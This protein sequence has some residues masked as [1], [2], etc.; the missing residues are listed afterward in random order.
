MRTILTLVQDIELLYTSQD[1]EQIHFLQDKL[2]TYQKSEHGDELGL[3]LLQ[4]PHGTVKYFGALTITVYLNTYGSKNYEQTFQQILLVIKELTDENFHSNSFII[5]KLLSCL[6]LIYIL[7]YEKFDPVLTFIKL[8]NPANASIGEFIVNLKDSKHLELLLYL[9]STIVEEVQKIP[10]SI[11]E[12]Q[13]TIHATIFNH[14]QTVLEYILQQYSQLPEEFI[15]L[16]LECLNSWVVYASTAEARSEVRYADDLRPFITLILK[17]LDDGFD[18]EKFEVYNKTFSVLAE[19]VDHIARALTP[20]KATLMDIFFGGEKFGMQMLNTIFSDQ[21]LMETYGSEVDN[22]INLIIGY[23]EL[24][25]IQLTRNILHPDTAKIV[26][27]AI[28]LTNAPGLP[29]VEENIS[30]Q[31]ISFWD[32]FAN[33]LIDDADVLKEAFPTLVA[34]NKQRS[35]D[36]LMEVAIVYFKKIQKSSNDVSQEF[37]RYRVLVADL[38]IIFYSILGVPLY[39]T[40]CDTVGSDLIESETALYLL[41]KITDDIQFFD[42]EDNGDNSTHPLV[43]EIAKLFEKNMIALVENQLDSESLTT[44]L[45]NFISVLPFFYKS[46]VGGAYL[47]LSFDFLFRVITTRKT[48][49]LPLIASRTVY[50]ICQD[51]EENLISFLP[52]LELVLVEMLRNPAIDSVIRE[53][54]TNSY[55]SI[56]RSRKVASELGDKIFAVLQVIEQQRVK[57]EDES[58]EDYAVSLVACIAEIGKACVYPEEIDE[59]FSEDQLQQVKIYWSQDPLNIR[60]MI[61]QNLRAFSL[62]SPL[63]AE[64]TIVTEKCCNILKCGFNEP[65]VGP[66][67]FDLELIFQYI[68]AKLQASTPHSIE[69]LHQLI[70]SV[71]LTHAKDIDQ[72]QFEALLLKAFVDIRSVIKSDEDLVKSSLDVFAAV[73]DTKP[74]LILYGPIMDGFIFP[75]ALDAF[76]KHEVPIV[77]STIKFWNAFITTKKGVQQDQEMVRHWMT[78]EQ[79]GTCLG[80]QLTNQL[81]S[82]FMASPRSSLDYYYSLFRYLINKFPLEVKKWLLFIVDNVPLGKD[83][84]DHDAKRQFVNKLMLTR[85]QRMSHNVLKDFWLA[86]WGLS[87]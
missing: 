34:E 68:L 70:I 67:T 79:N 69:Y 36:I 7:G 28:S 42:E 16:V 39:A 50:R 13:S 87:L 17:P 22:Y 5:R 74:K 59:Y 55:I 44:S 63:L 30:F 4:H 71:V 81:M 62:E 51:T 72:N 66:F 80:F 45:L 43:N 35:K 18:I 60:S 58:L 31:M 32:E 49:N 73:I 85:G 78:I 61:L 26:Q 33:T 20:F 64:K 75:F 84:L 53:R 57:I 52:Q 27:T 25:I 2:Q 48:G 10:S 38:F 40:L 77:R 29:I 37:T 3:Q 23:L 65:V 19:F 56:V 8:L 14:L 54:I 24:N 21:D 86:S 12:L 1:A 82:A 11:P 9:L 47:A 41:H 83:K 46:K 6:S 76:A 15:L